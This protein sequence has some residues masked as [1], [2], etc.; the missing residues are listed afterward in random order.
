MVDHHASLRSSRGTPRAKSSKPVLN[1][2]NGRVAGQHVYTI[3]YDFLNFRRAAK[4]TLKPRALFFIFLYRRVTVK[5]FEKN[6][7]R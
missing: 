2:Q 7:P 6:L 3:G 4:R 1:V 5:M